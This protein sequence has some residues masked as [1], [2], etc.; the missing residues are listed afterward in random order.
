MF[1]LYYISIHPQKCFTHTFD[2]E[3]KSVALKMKIIHYYVCVTTMPN[4]CVR[5]QGYYNTHTYLQL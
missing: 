2:L 1:A 5:I 3:H 4:S